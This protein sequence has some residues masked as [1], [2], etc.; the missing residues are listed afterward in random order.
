MQNHRPSSLFLFWIVLL[1]VTGLALA[2]GTGTIQGN[3][4]DPSGDG[5]PPC[6]FVTSGYTGFQGGQP[7]NL[8][9]A[10]GP[11]AL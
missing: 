2:Q 3:V 10:F 1:T 5:L 6:S 11:P 7:G 9:L 8:L 4:T